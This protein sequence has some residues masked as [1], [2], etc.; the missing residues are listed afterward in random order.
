MKRF[1]VVVVGGGIAGV[2]AAVSAARLG[3][4]TCLLEKNCVL[5][6]LATAGNVVVYLPICDGEG[7]QV[8]GGIAEEL[9]RM[10][11]TGA[12]GC[13]PEA[14][15]AGGSARERAGT[16]F[17]TSFNAQS[18][19]L[20]LEACLLEAGVD[21]WYDTRFCDVVMEQD[22]IADVV[23]YN[24]S[25]RIQIPAS[26]VVDAS[27]DADVCHSCQ[28]NTVSLATN[29]RSNWFFY[30][31]ETGVH[32]V[33]LTEPFTPDG[34]LSG[35]VQRGFRGDDGR[36]VSSHIIASHQLVRDRFNQ[37]QQASPLAS[38]VNLPSM[39]SMRMT[40]RLAGNSVLSEESSGI[41]PDDLVGLCPSW[42]QA[43]VVYGIPYS[44]LTGARTAN[45]ITAG[46]CISA[47]GRV[48]DLARAIPVCALTGE[49]A[50]TA[51]ALCASGG[52]DDIRNLSH[53]VLCAHLRQQGNIL[54]PSWIR[55][56]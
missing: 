15:L 14:W 7:N 5:G 55:G 10:A 45:L 29:V 18:Y 24:K 43:G 48:W 31:D 54:D 3:A 35:E 37:I 6:G 38:L 53:E 4:S 8:I 1:D 40:R 27:G 13:V 23:V 46:R 28:E 26:I 22:R 2:A 49:V 16:R 34:S 17:S 50:G 42:R 12:E 51:A 19:L 41:T 44:T 9:L 20:A 33:G 47:S 11:A 32:R 52:M 30:T 39:P 25:G 36:E 21:I 56:L